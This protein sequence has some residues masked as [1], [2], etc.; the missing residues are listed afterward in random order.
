MNLKK[1]F[2]IFNSLSN[3]GLVDCCVF[4]VN[5]F[6]SFI[7]ICLQGGLA[8]H[9]MGSWFVGMVARHLIKKL[10]HSHHFR[11]AESWMVLPGSTSLLYK[12]IQLGLHHT[13]VHDVMIHMQP[14]QSAFSFHLQP[15]Q[16]AFSNM[17]MMSQ[18]HLVIHQNN[19]CKT[20]SCSILHK[21]SMRTM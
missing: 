18:T 1:L 17:M 9:A 5:I 4:K 6:L 15:T 14:T 16:S 2:Q 20:R 13:H 21:I 10:C 12:R 8:N 19:P 7:I 11:Y 3:R